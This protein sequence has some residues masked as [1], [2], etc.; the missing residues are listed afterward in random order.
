MSHNV[1]EAFDAIIYEQ[2]KA[3]QKFLKEDDGTHKTDIEKL[4]KMTEAALSLQTTPKK[5][6]YLNQLPQNFS[7]EFNEYITTNLAKEQINT[8][9]QEAT[10]FYQSLLEKHAEFKTDIE[11]TVSCLSVSLKETDLKKKEISLMNINKNFSPE[12]SSFLKEKALPNINKELRKTVDFFESLLVD[13][14]EHLEEDLKSLKNRT[15]EALAD[16]VPIEEKQK[17]L[18]EVYNPNKKELFEYLQTKFL[19]KAVLRN[20]FKRP[21]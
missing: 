3:Y 19:E 10:E 17:T 12:F 9:I 18:F 8:A 15:M 7:Q 4:I 14:P 5:Q 2:L 16:T 13:K 1:A 6:Q 11:K 21:E 20:E